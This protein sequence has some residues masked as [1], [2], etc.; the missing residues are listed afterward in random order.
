MSN[1]SYINQITLDCLLNKEMRNKYIIRE[2]EKQMNNE[3]YKFYKK[4]ILKLFKEIHSGSEEIDIPQD[5]KYGYDIFIKSS[6]QY[7]KMIDENDLLQEEYEDMNSID[8][9]M[10]DLSN[11]KMDN[12]SE[13]MNLDNINL[14]RDIL[15]MRSV[16]MDLQHNLDKFVK[17]KTTKKE[18]HIIIPKMREIDLQNPKLKD[19]ELKKNINNKYEELYEK[20]EKNK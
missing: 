13:E 19:K 5:I 16:K 10:C 14:E 7:F 12:Q 11:I 18:E 20:K 3:D 17:R 1:N 6:I 9:Y 2:R 4:R 15:F 8:E